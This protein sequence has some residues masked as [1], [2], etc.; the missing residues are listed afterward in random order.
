MTT[1]KPDTLATEEKA[2]A[3][4]KAK[5]PTPKLPAVSQRNNEPRSVATVAL[6]P[7]E[8]IDVA[9]QVRTVFD[10]GS[11]S[12]L[13]AD[14]AA[15]G[16]LQP[17]L[18]NPNGTRYLVIAG[19]RR[20]RACRLLGHAAIPALLTAASA[21]ESTLMQMAENIQR[22]QLSA[23]DVA[24]AVRTLFDKLGSGQ[25]VADAVKKSKSWVSKHLAITC[26][27][28]SWHA[29]DLIETG[30]TEDFEICGI[31]D[32]ADKISYNAGQLITKAV[33]EGATRA[34]ARTLLKEM[35]ADRAKKETEHAETV[36]EHQAEREKHAAEVKK[37]KALFNPT[38]TFWKI[39]KESDCDDKASPAECLAGYSAGDQ[40]HM[41]AALLQF[42]DQ[43]EA[44]RD[45]LALGLTRFYVQEESAIPAIAF[46]F[47]YQGRPLE[48]LPIL[49]TLWKAAEKEAGE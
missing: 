49:E 43:G 11:I 44:C 30:V 39:E 29:R 48:L 1:T 3:K 16:M 41:L 28:F 13:A 14:I 47:G 27:D 45:N 32:Q 22:E 9:P 5:R 7:L 36:N 2:K 42:F 34:Q 46:A 10:D 15:R 19:E 6:V 31:V 20:L 35:K 33:Q 40:K 25:A 24:V 23:P 37:E 8:L 12:E 18:L 26:E 4:P 38:R 21:D 17:I